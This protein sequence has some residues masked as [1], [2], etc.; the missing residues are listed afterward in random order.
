MFTICFTIYPLAM[1]LR[2]N[3]LLLPSSLTNLFFGEMTD[4]SSSNPLLS[5]N[6]DLASRY[7]DSMFKELGWLAFQTGDFAEEF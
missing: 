3:D 7:N 1:S 6:R 4:I 5:F 2:P